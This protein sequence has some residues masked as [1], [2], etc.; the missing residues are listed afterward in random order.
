MTKI[1]EL[2]KSE[3]GTFSDPVLNLQWDYADENGWSALK[4]A[5]AINGYFLQDVT[6]SGVAYKKGELVPGFP[7]LL[8]DGSTSCGMWVF[9]GAFTK[10]GTNLMARR[11]K[12][13]TTGLGLYPNWTWCWPVNRRIIY[14]RASCD[15]DGNPWNPAKPLLKWDGCKWVG[16]VVDG[17]GN[18]AGQANRCEPEHG[19]LRRRKP[20][21]PAGNR[22]HRLHRFH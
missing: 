13:D 12:E 17:G 21:I 15:L 11:G 18:P 19:H 4:T 7:N 8:N 10:D 2:Y 3:G 1:K 6:V 14:N 20:E 9:S 16:D 5:K 22:R